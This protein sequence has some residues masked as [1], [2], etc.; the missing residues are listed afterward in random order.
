MRQSIQLILSLLL[1]F[2]LHAQPTQFTAGGAQQL[3]WNW[4]PDI[5]DS[6]YEF[7]LETY[8]AVYFLH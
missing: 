5:S 8:N 3:Y 4:R 7:V 1:G 6:S 2:H